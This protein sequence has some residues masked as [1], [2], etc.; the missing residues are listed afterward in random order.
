MQGFVVAEAL[1]KDLCPSGL[2]VIL[3]VAHVIPQMVKAP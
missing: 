1:T 3:A 2:P